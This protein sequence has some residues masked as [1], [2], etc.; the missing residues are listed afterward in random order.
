M[1][2]RV[3]KLNDE[4]TY[5]DMEAG[6]FMQVVSVSDAS[7][8]DITW[9]DGGR[10]QRGTVKNVF[11]GQKKRPGFEFQG[12]EIRGTAGETVTLEI[13]PGD[14]DSDLA[15]TTTVITNTEAQAV[16]VVVVNVDAT[17]A[18]VEIVNPITLTATAVEMMQG[19]VVVGAANKLYVQGPLTDAQLRATAVPVSGPLTDA[20]LRLTDVATLPSLAD[21]LTG[22]S[23]GATAAIAAM[24]AAD[25]T[26]RGFYARNAG[27]DA[28]AL[29]QVGG[30]YAD[31]AIVLQ[32]GETWDEHIA[33][34]AAWYCICAAG[35]TATLK[36]LAAA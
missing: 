24:L 28:V 7:T 34:G 30:T 15:D 5:T 33:P 35:E 32:M 9:L 26:R 10:Q 31:A 23:V 1:K 27:P 22:S 13:G 19:G 29:V 17:P 4:G 21:T 8:I 20:Q 12:Y 14:A 25:A 3:L 16:P 18:K 36:I 6:R 11:A 2:T